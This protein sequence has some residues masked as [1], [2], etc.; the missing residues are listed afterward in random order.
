[1]SPSC[2]RSN[3]CPYLVCFPLGITRAHRPNLFEI[4]ERFTEDVSRWVRVA[5]YQQL[6]PLISTCEKGEVTPRLL[7]C[8]TDM[9][10]QSESGNDSDFAEYCAFSFPAVAQSV[11]KE[12]WGDLEA[13][14]L[15]LIKDVQWKVRKSLAHSL[16]EI[17]RIVGTEITEKTLTQAYD[18]F[19]KDLDEVKV[20][21]VGN[22][23]E[24]MEV[25]GE[26]QREKYVPVICQLPSETDNWRCVLEG[27]K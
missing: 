23:S 7:K 5:A 15:T 27:W 17:A 11:G 25:L 20:G 10:F 2:P 24:F 16:H 8:F 9:A 13:A 3:N 21:V 12:N 1:M 6:G 4:F 19:L 14:Y 26:D 18:L 22:I